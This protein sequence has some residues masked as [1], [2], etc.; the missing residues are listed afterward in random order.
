MLIDTPA[1]V[2]IAV[3]NNLTWVTHNAWE[4]SRVEGLMIEDWEAGEEF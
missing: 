2:A 4:F 3:A 1:L